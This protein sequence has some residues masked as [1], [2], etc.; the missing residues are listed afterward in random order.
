MDDKAY[1]V[2]VLASEPTDLHHLY[3]LIETAPECFNLQA[4]NM[5]SQSID[6]A[7]PLSDRPDVIVLVSD[8]TT[9]AD[10]QTVTDVCR[11]AADTPVVLLTNSSDT[12]TRHRATVAGVADCLL[13]WRFDAGVLALGLAYAIDRQRLAMEFPADAIAI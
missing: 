3:R 2:L 6:T 11:S 9:P 12:W 10:I 8:I 13:S 1:R 4:V 7:F 5:D